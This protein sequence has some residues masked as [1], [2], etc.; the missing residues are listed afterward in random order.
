MAKKKKQS[1][2]PEPQPIST[3]EVL[4]DAS[5]SIG[6]LSNSA[7]AANMTGA[8]LGMSTIADYLATDGRSMI[9]D[10]QVAATANKTIKTT[11]GKLTKSEGTLKKQQDTLKTLEE[12]LAAATPGSSKYKAITRKINGLKPKIEKTQTA[13]QGFQTKIADANTTL[14]SGPSV[15]ELYKKADPDTYAAIDR[16][17]GFASKI[18]QITP[19]GQRYLDAAAAGYQ[20][21]DIGPNNIT[22]ARIAKVQNIRARQIAA[23]QAG[24]SGLGSQ[25]MNTA[26]QRLA[27]GGML[28]TEASR[29]AVQA[30]R[31]GMAA[32]GMATGNS[33]LAAE[34][35]NR[36]RYSQQR[37]QQD[38]AFAQGVEGQDLSRRLAN[39]SEA[40]RIQQ[41]NQQA[42]LTAQ[43]ANQQTAYNR[44]QAQAQ[45]SQQAS[46]ANQNNTYNT[47]T[48]N[49]QNRL[50]GA[51]QNLNQLGAASNYVDATN[52]AGFA[53][54]VDAAGVSATYNPLFRNLG[55]SSQN[56]FGTNNLGTVA[57]A[58]SINL[59]G[60][61][62]SFNA[63]MA[64]T[65][66]NSYWN[67]Q[68][69]LQ[70]AGVVGESTNKAGNA[71]MGAG[72]G[73]AGGA[74]AGAAMGS[75]VPGIGTLAGAA[76]GGAMGAAGGGGAGYFCWIARAAW[77]EDN[78]RWIE[79]RDSM[80][81]HAP[82][83]FVAA[84]MQHGESIARHI[85][86]PARRVVA[87]VILST[88]QRLWT[89]AK[90]TL[91]PA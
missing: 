37:F 75:V 51:Q 4:T 29:D 11:T 67:N 35:L 8:Q 69:A 62:A 13:V 18:G 22:A 54:N 82:E 64:A 27:L 41:A 76:I 55:M 1:P 45:L 16:A 78:P 39:V 5:K 63:N 26:G 14:Q 59:A 31:A 15:T 90:S 24:V 66:Y 40:N 20:S 56:H 68:A 10:P 43:Q 87:R 12:Q 6:K 77:G 46:L 73:M 53:A 28:S 81:T 23:E 44:A 91:Q 17:T 57:L 25:L 65:N 86:T 3:T 80:L 74:I 79:F 19:E 71:A 42:N 88:L 47:N 7:A 30:A 83:W 36:D 48:F 70:G 38:A 34:L 84:Y 21:R 85:H 52:K 33:A 2:P 61:V 9:L 50:V 60:N 72:V 49:E 89:P 58:P 32:R